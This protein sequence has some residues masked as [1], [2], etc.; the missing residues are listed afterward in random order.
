MKVGLLGAF[1]INN[2]GD[3]LVAIA[4]KRG[5]EELIKDIDVTIFSPV[6]S[7]LAVSPE[8]MGE[9]F[10][11]KI[12]NLTD[13]DFWTKM[14]NF[15]ALII[16]GG[17]LLVPVPEFE[18][19]LS[20][21]NEIDR[22][23][24]PKIAWNAIG[25]QWSPLHEPELS[26]WYEKIKNAAEAVDYLSVRSLT[27]QKLLERV[28]CPVDKI[29]LVPDP[30]INLKINNIK[31]IQE[32]L[33]KKLNIN[34]DIPLI[35]VSVGPELLKYPLKSFMQELSKALEVIQNNRR[36]IIIFP[37]GH[38]YGDY[39]ACQELWKLS[40]KSL[41]IREPLNAIEIWAM[42]GMLDA[43]LSVRYHGII[44]AIANGIPSL[45]LDCYLSNDTTSSKIRDLICQ[46][47]L[48]GYYY[49]PMIATCGEA[50]TRSFLLPESIENY[51]NRTISSHIIERTENLLTTNS[52]RIWAATRRSQSNAALDH[53][54]KMARAL[55]LI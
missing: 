10:N 14:S 15:D 48:E 31:E 3:N 44:A 9:G 29:R 36:Q 32:K 40:P 25:S 43:Y 34:N 7:S 38:I 16:G 35:G 18:Q 12:A 49:S 27:T 11:W 41:F 28:G 22:C 20:I 8:D 23:M 2:S 45:A 21:G 4:T 26:G 46:T 47:N 6:F 5:L 1:G 24:L 54:E 42:V 37:F 52:R 17:G 51:L 19:F 55:E 33:R 39:I 13:N 50:M 30:V 53:F